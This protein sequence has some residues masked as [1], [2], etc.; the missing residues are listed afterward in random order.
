MKVVNAFAQVFSIFAFLTIGSLLM[1][2]AL[3]ILSMNDAMLKVREL[4]ANPWQSVQTGIVG[5]CFI[6]VGLIFVK[7]IVKRGR[8]TD[9]I[10]YQSETGPVMVSVAAIEDIVK[11]VLK[12]FHLIKDFKIKTLFHGKNVEIRLRLVLWSGGQIPELLGDLQEQIRLRVKKLFGSESRIE[13]SCDVQRVEEH[14]AT[15]DPL[16]LTQDKKETV[17]S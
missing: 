17:S 13:I 15:L 2:V 1:M 9:A 10:I 3:R 11:K 7:M 4:Y 12:R 16:E 14:D 6:S 5:I 8:Q